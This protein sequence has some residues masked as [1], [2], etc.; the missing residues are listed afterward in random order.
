M[1][2]LRP[3]PIVKVS[4][5]WRWCG[6]TPQLAAFWLAEQARQCGDGELARWAGVAARHRCAGRALQC[7]AGEM[8]V[9]GGSASV[10][11]PGA[12][13]R[14]PDVATHQ[15]CGADGCSCVAE[16]QWRARRRRRAFFLFPK[17]IFRGGSL[18]STVSKN[19][20]LWVVVLKEPSWKSIFRGGFK[21]ASKNH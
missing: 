20:F 9:C 7:G 2:Q 1:H 10:C 14:R 6:P 15:R 5:P 19:L 18:K 13:V 21:I 17:I 11:W 3:W 4:H 8:D 12:A 16:R